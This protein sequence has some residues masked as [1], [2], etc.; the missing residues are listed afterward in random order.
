M[1]QFIRKIA[2]ETGL[3]QC[4]EFGSVTVLVSS[5]LGLYLRH[6]NYLLVV[7]LLSLLTLVIPRV[8]YPFAVFWS[9]FGKLLSRVSSGILLTLIYVVV[10]TPMGLMRRV[11]S[12]GLIKQKQFK[13]SRLSVMKNRNHLY[14]KED[15]I[16]TF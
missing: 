9:A 3:E 10:V 5:V 8:F 6:Y 7:F 13:K 2:R 1:M 15:L 14:N 4:R 11:R 16:H 12:S